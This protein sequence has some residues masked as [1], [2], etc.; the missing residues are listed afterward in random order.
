MIGSLDFADSSHSAEPCRPN[1]RRLIIEQAFKIIRPL[2]E[3]AKEFQMPKPKEVMGC[4][5]NVW[6]T[7][8]ELP[9]C[10]LISHPAPWRYTLTAFDVVRR[11]LQSLHSS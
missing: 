6:I 1:A 2:L 8:G 11:T 7:V 3:D 5:P 10:P 9:R 4:A